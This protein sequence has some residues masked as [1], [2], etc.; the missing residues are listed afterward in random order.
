MA[1][2]H[3]RAHKPTDPWEREIYFH[4]GIKVSSHNLQFNLQAPQMR[5]QNM[6]RE[7]VTAVPIFKLAGQQKW[8][9]LEEL[10]V[11]AKGACLGSPPRSFT[12]VFSESSP[13]QR[14]PQSHRTQGGREEPLEVSSPTS[15]SKVGPASRADRLL[16]LLERSGVPRVTS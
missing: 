9:G 1:H 10:P 7:D 16:R 14:L 5:P 4:K 6:H 13:E 11:F 3:C 15:C 12:S 2:R 8:T